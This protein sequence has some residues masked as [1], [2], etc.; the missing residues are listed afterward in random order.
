MPELPELLRSA[1]AKGSSSSTADSDSVT[2][3]GDEVT[4]MM[5]E[6]KALELQ[7]GTIQAHRW[8]A[9]AKLV[10]MSYRLQAQDAAWREAERR[11]AESKRRMKLQMNGLVL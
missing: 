5:D 2:F 11:V 8:G 7:V 3:F 1:V 10:K 6:R 9:E 4:Q